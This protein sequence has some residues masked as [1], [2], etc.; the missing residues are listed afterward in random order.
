LFEDENL[1][2]IGK[3]ILFHVESTGSNH[4][5]PADLL[6]YLETKFQ[7]SLAAS[8]AMDDEDCWNE[9]QGRKRRLIF[10]FMEYA[11]SRKEKKIIEKSELPKQTMTWNCWQSFYQSSKSWL[12]PVRSKNWPY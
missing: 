8:L 9:S 2:S 10:Q 6:P 11:K 4:I 1:K 5:D 12:W 3:A 7:R